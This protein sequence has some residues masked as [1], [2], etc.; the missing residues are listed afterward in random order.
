[1]SA[2]TLT[3]QASAQPDGSE[4]AV[5]DSCYLHRLLVTSQVRALHFPTHDLRRTQKVLRRMVDKGILE[6][7][8]HRRTDEKVFFVTDKGARIAEAGPVA[9]RRHRQTR[10][11]AEGSLRQHTLAVNDVGVSFVETARARGDECSPAD[12]QHEQ[13]FRVPN[14]RLVPD[15]VLHYSVCHDHCDE[16]VVR[17]LEI[18][19]ATESLGKLVEKLRV[20]DKLHTR[21]AWQD[22]FIV[23]PK[24]LVV[25]CGGRDQ[26]A[27]IRRR[28][29][30]LA[31]C[32]VDTTLRRS[33]VTI[34]V[35]TLAE[36]VERGP[37]ERIFWEPDL[38]APVDLVGEG[39][40]PRPDAA[41]AGPANKEPQPP[42]ARQL[43]RSGR[44]PLTRP[45]AGRPP[46]GATGTQL[47]LIDG[48][49]DGGPQ[50]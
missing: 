28:D 11:S 9:V 32:R 19:R 42:A 47:Q 36:L 23:F 37:F 50:R 1:M 46:V 24:V 30:L 13:L 3:V 40:Q 7:Q 17:F 20:Y 41:T 8:Q 15:A 33:Q 10:E 16:L 5:L 29:T 25:L 26:A 39:P 12:W 6:F 44:P 45:Q 48:K 38:A 49:P 43:S 31:L 27:L 35:T 2:I 22:R 14:A 21:G 34:T 4:G 18:D